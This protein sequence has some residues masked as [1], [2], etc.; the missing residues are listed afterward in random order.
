MKSLNSVNAPSFI[1]N[2]IDKQ[3]RAENIIE[4][5]SSK[6]K[7]M[8]KDRDKLDRFLENLEE[9]LKI[10]PGIGD[11]LSDVPVLI[12]MIKDFADGS[13]PDIP[14]GTAIAALAS[15]IYVVSPI[16]LV[17]DAVPVLGFADDAAVIATCTKLIE[18]D[19]N[20]Y[21]DWKKT[22]ELDLEK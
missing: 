6:A 18:S 12:S 21:K 5:N 10:I 4:N 1:K 19:L 2:N 16:D 11:K 15:L 3:N 20:D 14:A 17:S 9:K 13:Y 22:N 7:E 8:L